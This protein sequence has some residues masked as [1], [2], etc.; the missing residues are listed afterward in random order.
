MADTKRGDLSI[1]ST[2]DTAYTITSMGMFIS[3]HTIHE[4]KNWISWNFSNN[5]I[6]QSYGFER[7]VV[8]REWE[9]LWNYLDTAVNFRSKLPQEERASRSPGESE[10]AGGSWQDAVRR[11]TSGWPEPVHEALNFADEVRFD[12][13][14]EYQ[15]VFTPSVKHDLSGQIVDVVRFLA[16]EPESMMD[17]Q[18]EERSKPVVKILINAAASYRVKPEVIVRRG[19]IIVALI[20]LLE[21]MNMRCEVIMVVALQNDVRGGKENALQYFV[22]LK[23]PDHPLMVDALMFMVANP[24]SLRR[25]AFSVMETEPKSVRTGMDIHKWGGY[26]YP[27]EPIPYP[28]DIYVP[29]ISMSSTEFNSDEGA[30]AWLLEVLRDQG[31]TFFKNKQEI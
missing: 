1:V 25:I 28:H 20:D 30:K 17:I 26:G 13:E 16:E 12:I 22:T 24:G 18:V 9:S 7:I 6:N 11:A 3:E 5:Q 8:V 21:S 14:D 2:E 27:A 23:R 10:W 31:L 19:A 4:R 29:P 15:L